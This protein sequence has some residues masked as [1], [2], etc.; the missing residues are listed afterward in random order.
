MLLLWD[1]QAGGASPLCRWREAEVEVTEITKDNR[2]IRGA[3]LWGGPAPTEEPGVS[4]KEEI[5]QMLTDDSEVPGWTKGRLLG[6]HFGSALGSFCFDLRFLE[7]I[8]LS[9]SWFSGKGR[10]NWWVWNPGGVGPGQ[11]CSKPSGSPCTH[12]THCWGKPP[13]VPSGSE[14]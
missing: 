11:G 9:T 3:G 8:K 7:F 12:S 5:Q 14:R 2:V 6:S 4:P 1:C 10:G 13:S